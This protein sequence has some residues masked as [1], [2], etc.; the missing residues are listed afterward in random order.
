MKLPSFISMDQYVYELPPERIAAY[1]SEQRDQSRLLVFRDD[2]PAGDCFTNLSRYMPEGGLMVFNDT[3]VIRARLLFQKPTG[4]RIE[5]FCLEP[6]SPHGELSM[7]F[8]ACSSVSW[9]CLVGN[10]RKWSKG[11]LQM[12][13]RAGGEDAILYAGKSGEAGGAYLIDFWWE[14]AHIP[15]AEIIGLAGL[16]PLPPYI[17]REAEEA[18]NERYQTI[19]ARHHGSVA[20]PT[21]GLHFTPAVMKSLREKNIHFEN[22]TLHVG[23][24]TFKPVSHDDIRMHEMHNEKII[25]QRDTVEALLKFRGLLTAVGTTSMRTLESLYCYGAMLEQDPQAKFSIGQ[26]WPYQ[27]AAPDPGREK[28]LENILRLMDLKKTN[29][30]SGETRLIIVPGYRFR[31]SDK[32]ITN[33]HMP[34]STLLLLVAAFAGKGWRKAYN[35]ALQNGFRFLSY[36]DSCLFFR[37][38]Q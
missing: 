6:V 18:D 11:P 15:F 16:V 3:R 7:A 1:P 26:W 33:F 35:Y 30:I 14:P 2:V 34:R 8:E 27:H 37:S 28:A 4:A 5:V 17:E 31:M 32:L 23:A 9:K 25:I 29:V 10:A 22:V 36:G 38:A 13:I 24:G 20:A 19:Y 12:N 21:A